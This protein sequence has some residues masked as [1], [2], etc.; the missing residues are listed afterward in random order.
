MNEISNNCEIRVFDFSSGENRALAPHL[1]ESESGRTVVGYA[2]VFNQESR[3]LYDRAK[4]REFIERIEPRAVTEEFLNRQDIKFLFNHDKNLLLARSTFG[5]GTLKFEI[6]DYGVK[7]SVDL[8]NTTA[9]ND[10]L[11]LIRR[12]DVFGC[13]FAFQ[14]A[15]DGYV[16][17]RR[18]GRNVRTIIRFESIS[19]FSIVVDP[20]YW[21]TFVTTRD[22]EAPD[23]EQDPG[24]DAEASAEAC[25]RIDAEIKIVSLL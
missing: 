5:G 25:R 16:D 17:E 9:G 24:K 4:R 18:D 19:D 10:A 20:A 23:T 8:P 13:S 3:V 2:I 21:G 1:V 14:Y 11:E 7:F 12:G 6:D 15:K 22:F